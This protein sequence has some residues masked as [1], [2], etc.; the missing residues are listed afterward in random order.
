MYEDIRG[1]VQTCDACQRRGNPKVNNILH[2]IEPRAPF[3]RIGI[4]IVG[5]LTITKKG[6]R[7]IVTAM[8]Y[9]TKWPIAKAIKETTAKTVS[10]FIYEK[11]ICEHGCLQVLQSDQRTHFVNRVIQNLSEKFKIKHRLS[12]HITHKRMG[13]S[14]VLIK[15][16]AKN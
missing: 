15:H 13:W 9:F 10:K 4:D 1:Y 7:Y 6:N 16:S 3:Q 5:P 8:D 11:I 14:N 12:H 2:P